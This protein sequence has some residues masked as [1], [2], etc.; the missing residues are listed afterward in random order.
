LVT[1]I[2]SWLCSNVLRA[3]MIRTMA[4]STLSSKT[5]VNNQTQTTI[6]IRIKYLFWRDCS[7]P[8]G[9]SVSLEVDDFS[10]TASDDK[11]KICTRQM[12]H[13]NW[14]TSKHHKRNWNQDY[15]DAI[16]WTRVWI[17]PG[18]CVIVLYLFGARSLP[19]PR[20]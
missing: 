17:V 7:T 16:Q 3:F 13:H 11:S 2:T 20:K 8:S 4:A 18:K 1:S 12:T 10:S 14:V 5:Q 9:K 19:Q 15:L 6:L